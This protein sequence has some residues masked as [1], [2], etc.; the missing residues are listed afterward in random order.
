[1]RAKR[2]LAKLG[3]AAGAAVVALLLAEAIVRYAKPE[4]VRQPVSLGT[5]AFARAAHR[6]GTL[7]GLE[8]ELAPDA[9]VIV[10]ETRV[11]TNSL[12]MRGPETT[13]EKPDGVYRIAAIGDSY[14]FG[15]GVNDEDCLP[16][17]LD[18]ALN[19]HGPPGRRFEV[20]NFGASGYSTRDEAIVLRHRALAFD[21]DL[22]LVT[23]VLNDPELHPFHAL[24]SIFHER[25]WW[26]RSHLLQ[27]L[28]NRRLPSRHDRDYFEA[29]HDPTTKGW[30]SVVTAFADIRESAA[31]IGAPVVLAIVP[32]LG[33]QGWD[34]NPFAWIH[35]QV[36]DEAR[37]NGFEVLD[38]GDAVRDVV[39]HPVHLRL[40]NGVHATPFG[41][42]VFAGAV[43]RLLATMQPEVFGALR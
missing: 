24:H 39:P 37:R 6:P 40:E 20:L 38:L 25:E 11:T 18:R 10:G 41:N 26:E 19:R 5:K 33:N 7:P 27:L 21:P 4:G 23:Y 30:R 12:G 2:P 22:I 3:V 31:S 28:V 8:Y 36:A 9:D 34:E 35:A 17:Q 29:L 14:T 16:A 32:N 42:Q 1:M 13:V 43:Q 15:M